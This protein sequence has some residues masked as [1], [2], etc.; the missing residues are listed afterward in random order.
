MFCL[1]LFLKVQVVCS[2][3][4]NLM[5]LHIH[6]YMYIHLIYIYIYINKISKKVAQ[7]FVFKVENQK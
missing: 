1:A 3:Q 5:L 7:D 2:K 4:G 6:I